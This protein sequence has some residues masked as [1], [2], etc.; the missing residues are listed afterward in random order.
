MIDGGDLV[1]TWITKL[2][3]HVEDVIIL[4]KN[5]TKSI[6]ANKKQA[7]LVAVNDAIFGGAV[8]AKAA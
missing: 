7:R 4:V 6:L 1:S 8:Y 2:E 3:V 5:M